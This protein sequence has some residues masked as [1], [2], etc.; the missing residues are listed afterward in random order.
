MIR[1]ASFNKSAAFLASS[2]EILFI[3]S[4]KDFLERF[5]I[6]EIDEEMARFAGLWLADGSY[7]K[8]SVLVSIVEPK[9]RE[10]VETIAKRF[11]LKTTMH[12]DGITLKINSKPFKQFLENVLELKGNAY[13]KKMPDWV[14]RLEKQIAAEL[15]NGYFSGDG[16]VRKNDIAICSSSGQL[17]KDTQTLLLRFGIPLR[18]KWKLRKDKTF[19]SRISGTKFLKRFAEEIGFCIT[20]KSKKQG[21]KKSGKH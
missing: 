20:R 21:K 4:N 1:P 7:D 19:E 18:I 2:S 11:N 10:T 17:L 3:R 14:F 9:A 15:L 6:I 8:N 12:S 5:P 13:T 16:W